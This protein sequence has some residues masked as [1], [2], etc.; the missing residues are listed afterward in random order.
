MKLNS[1]NFEEEKTSE[2]FTFIHCKMLAINL[3]RTLNCPGIHL[4][5]GDLR[6]SKLYSIFRIVFGNVTIFNPDIFRKASQKGV[7][8]NVEIPNIQT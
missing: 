3:L 7:K 5:S 1:R 8:M 4:I 2:Q 6:T